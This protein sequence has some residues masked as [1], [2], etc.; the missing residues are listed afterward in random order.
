MAI[1]YSESRWPQ[2]DDCAIRGVKAGKR[3]HYS[4][5]NT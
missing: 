5:S 1:L 4:A 3:I 2:S